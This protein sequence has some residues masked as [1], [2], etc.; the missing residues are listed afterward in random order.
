MMSQP[1]EWNRRK[2]SMAGDCFDED[3]RKRS[4]TA[5]VLPSD[6][7][8]KRMGRMSYLWRGKGPK[9]P[10]WLGLELTAQSSR[11]QNREGLMDTTVEDSPLVHHASKNLLL[12]IATVVMILTTTSAIAHRRVF[13]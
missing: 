8:P 6:L 3:V 9:S 2:R 10:V 12:R 1:M 13:R 7:G 11:E 4:V 5:A